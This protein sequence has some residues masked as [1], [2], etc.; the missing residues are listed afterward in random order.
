[1]TYELTEK[2]ILLDE[3]IVQHLPSGDYLLEYA[4]KD[5]AIAA[6]RGD[7]TDEEWGEGDDTIVEYYLI[8]VEEAAN[9]GYGWP[10]S[11]GLV[12]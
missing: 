10:L 7:M 4:S 11:L 1:M 3:I 9:A 12:K 8:D 5:E 6:E 2:A